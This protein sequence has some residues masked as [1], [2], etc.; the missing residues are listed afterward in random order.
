MRGTKSHTHS[1]N[2]VRRALLNAAVAIPI[3]GVIWKGMFSDTPHVQEPS[4]RR[5]YLAWRSALDFLEGE[6]QSLPGDEQDALSD[7]VYD[8][9]DVV[10]NTPSATPMD[11]LYKVIAYTFDGEH[12][13][14]GGDPG[15]DQIL[16]EARAFLAAAPGEV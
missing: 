6:G 9:A 5:A 4:V 11:T 1:H 7:R 8:L 10:L 15:A 16:A 3:T 2:P 12:F 13:L 14:A